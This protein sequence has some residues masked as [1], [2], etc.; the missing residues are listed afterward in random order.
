MKWLPAVLHPKPLALVGLG[1]AT[2]TLLRW[3]VG[4]VLPSQHGLPWATVLVNLVGSFALGFLL[5]VLLRRGPESVADRDLRLLLG[6]GF[7]GGF[8]TFSTFAM[9]LTAMLTDGRVDTALVYAGLS[10]FGGT[11]AAGLGVLLA[12]R[13][14]A[15]R[16][17][18]S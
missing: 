15:G 10:L 12:A 11:L 6:T 8:T 16:K 3:G 7:L 5:D 4:H 18:S 14:V 1:G 9:D 17:A 2:G 13:G